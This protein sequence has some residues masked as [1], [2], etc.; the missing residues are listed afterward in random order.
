MVS[1]TSRPI[2]VPSILD[3]VQTPHS[4]GVNC[5]IGTVR[6][7]AEGKSVK[8]LEY[9][10]Y[11]PMGEKLMAEIEEE[12][13]KKWHLH[14][15]VLVHRIGLLQVG[16]VAVVT[17]VSASHRAEA[18]DACRYAI[19]RIKEVVPIWKKE[20]FEEG[21]AWVVGQHDVDYGGSTPTNG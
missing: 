8:A 21:T 4:G 10:A 1:I 17:A 18:F 16:D 14:A 13:R 19:D 5:F 15:I 6:N 9:T 20:F 3:A 7:H 11:V 2:D 12:M